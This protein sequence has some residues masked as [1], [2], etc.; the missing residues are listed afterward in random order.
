MNKIE[1]C[2]ALN[3]VTAL[4]E[5]RSKM[6]S[7]I[8]ADPKLV[9]IL[10]SIIK[11]D[12]NPVSCKASWILEYVANKDLKPILI[13]INDFITILNSISLESSIR[14][15]AKI[16]ELLV[17]NEF[18]EKNKICNP[19]LNNEH[20][21]AITEAAFDWLIGEHKIAPKAYSITILLWLGFKIDWIHP[22][23]IPI[24]KQNYEG[25]SAAYKARARQTLKILE[26]MSSNKD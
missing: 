26:K 9:P 7:I 14:P 10:I 2:E 4:R 12:I 13:Y 3:Y 15:A 16:C 5:K 24:L 1:L 8:L 18:S 25:G 19:K 17:L 20:L 11:D 6:A 21:N 22:E 23:L